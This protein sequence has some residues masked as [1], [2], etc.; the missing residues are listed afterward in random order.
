MSRVEV[1]YRVRCAPADVGAVAQAI[2]L[3]QSVELPAA[4]IHDPR[5][6]SD[7][8]GRVAVW[9]VR[10]DDLF[11][12]DVELASSTM[13]GDVAQV[14]NMLFGN[15]SLHDHVELVDVRFPDD[16]L[17][18]FPGPRFG[19]AGLRKML[20][21]AERPL[22]CAA[23]KPQGLS[24]ERLAALCETLARA[25]IDV[26][27]DDHGLADQDYSPFAER[28]K[29]CQRAIERSYAATGHRA[30]YAPSVVGS[31]RRVAA[32]VRIAQEE[33]ARALL[34]APSLL[35]LPAFAEIV[36]EDVKVP[37]IAH[38]SFGGATRIAHPLLIGTIYRALGADAV[39]F[40]HASGR[41]APPASACR[42]L[43]ARARA[44]LGAF[45]SV[46][47]VP[48]GGLQ[49]ATLGDVV[50]FYGRE[51]MLLVG[52]SLLIDE[53]RVGERAAQFAAAV[54][55]AAHTHQ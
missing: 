1:T 13:G 2:A 9:R 54:R 22:T 41:F 24:P 18:A 37:V 11:D 21:V 16:V 3:E 44:S 49:L 31:P 8:A 25:G 50:A 30:A 33:G 19:A 15:S 47:P 52:G 42:E 36:R 46:L 29:A 4:A 38:P 5:I 7:I 12:V 14:V 39:I 10:G 17:A 27:K 20:G 23:L 45:A 6:A 26:I 43:A 28:V 48:A 34:L 55:E 40:P 51:V 53:G 35:G 32:Q